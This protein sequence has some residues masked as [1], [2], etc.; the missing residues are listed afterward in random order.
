MDKQK[1]KDVIIVLVLLLLVIV[2]GTSYSEYTKGHFGDATSEIGPFKN[3]IYSNNLTSQIS[4]WYADYAYFICNVSPWFVRGGAYNF[5]SA[6]GMF[7]FSHG[8]GLSDEYFGFR[9]VLAM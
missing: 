3:F 4:S 8:N 6:S 5:G 9:I 1:K 2:I 7:G